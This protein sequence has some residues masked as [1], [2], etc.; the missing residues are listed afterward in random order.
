MRKFIVP[1]FL[2]FILTFS[3]V[4]IQAQEV[5]VGSVSW[6]SVSNNSS[7]ASYLVREGDTLW[8][9]AQNFGVD[10]DKLMDDNGIA[11]AGV[12]YPGQRLIVDYDL[13]ED[14][15]ED[16]SYIYYVVRS[17]DI[18][19]SIAQEHNTTVE[20][21][22]ELNSIGS[23]YEIYIGQEL[24]VPVDVEEEDD[25]Q[26]SSRSWRDRFWRSWRDRFSRSSEDKSTSI[27]DYYYEV[28]EDDRIWSI[29]NHFGVKI[30]DLMEANE[31]SDA[32]DLSEGDLL[33]VSLED[34]TKYNS[35]K[36]TVERLNNQ[37]RVQAGESLADI[38]AYFEV[39]KQALRIINGLA[40]EEELR[41]G[42]SL[43]MPV[44]RALFKE[45]QL[46]TVANDG[47]Y[48]FDI[49]FENGISIRSIL[50]ANYWQD[51]NQRLAAGATILVPQDEDSKTRWIEYQDGRPINSWFG[52]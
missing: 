16:D 26:E 6:S 10:I 9:I 22:V 24:R 15:T 33:V 5:V 40:D 20:E 2:A 18:L 51:A 28:Q 25:N 27:V 46:H 8:Q 31:L 38:A 14:S 32:N 49:A 50:R 44:N 13:F 11:S 21:L 29:A 48:I 37:Y 23:G 36:S 19:W 7:A 42:Q 45:H 4:P 41:S 3:V 12:I 35:L 39:P 1:A 47:K 52:R 34:S 17:G 30:A 43:L